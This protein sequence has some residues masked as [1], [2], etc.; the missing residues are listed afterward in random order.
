MIKTYTDGTWKDYEE[1]YK[2]MGL[3][4]DRQV[5]LSLVGGGGKTTVIRR[6]Q[7]EYEKQGVPNIVTTTTH[8]QRLDADWFL[9]E[10]SIE[11]LEQILHT[12]GKVWMGRHANDLRIKGFSEE[13]LE[14]VFS[15]NH[16]VFVEADGAKMFPCKAPESHEP[17]IP[18]ETNL[19]VSMYGLDALNKK[20]KDTCF[21]PEKVAKILGKT[22]EDDLT[23]EDMVSL[24]IHHQ[25]GRKAVTES[26]DYQ[27]V[28]N[29]ADD[30][31]TIETAMWMAERMNE[32]G[33]KRVHITSRLMSSDWVERPKNKIR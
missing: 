13:F 1:L 32:A 30:G 10:P 20:I 16:S 9:N 29:K 23:R 12:Y 21:R 2:A 3:A 28:L 17:V 18:K 33:V 31:K 26:M 11:K 6:L 7:S 15:L 27:V 8:I 22:V 24:A 5:I 14:K 19:V 25:G 4:M